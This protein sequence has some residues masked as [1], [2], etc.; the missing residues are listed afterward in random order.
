[1]LTGCKAVFTELDRP[2]RALLKRLTEGRT[3]QRALAK[4]QWPVDKTGISELKAA[5]E[6]YRTVL[7]LMLTVL[8]IVENRQST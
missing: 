4:L 7:H 3:G 1:M 5:L 8:Q 2:V 6:R